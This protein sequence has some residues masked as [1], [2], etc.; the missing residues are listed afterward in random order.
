MTSGDAAYVFEKAKTAV[1][2]TCIMTAEQIEL[3]ED[4]LFK[5]TRKIREERKAQEEAQKGVTR[6]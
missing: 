6:C 2:L 5:A 1:E 4:V 3:F